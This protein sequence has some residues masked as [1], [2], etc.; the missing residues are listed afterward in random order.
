M[1]T[2]QVSQL[3]YVGLE[4]SDLA[5]WEDFA[6]RILGLEVVPTDLQG[7][8]F[9]RMDENHHRIAL[10]EGPADD[11]SHV[12]WE[13]PDE[14]V[15]RTLAVRLEA[16]GLDVHPG[17]TAEARERRVD[18][19]VKLRDPDG[20]DTEI[21][22]GPLVEPDRPFCS[23]RPISRFVA[24]DL[25]LGHCV[26]NVAD[27]EASMQ[28]YRDGL[29]LLISDFIDIDMGDGSTVTAAFLH[30]GPRHHSVALVEVPSP[31]RMHHV[32]FEVAD[33]DDVGVAHD[34]C[35]DNQIPITMGMGR[36][37]NDRMTSFYAESP[38]G[39]QVEYG[40][41]GRLIDD[42]DWQVQTYDRTSIWGHRAPG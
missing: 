31:K 38:S 32:M 37:P 40:Y 27:Y 11:V 16:Q 10:R 14:D 41:G 2:S 5:A 4:V 3:G 34:L 25:G 33:V 17:T 9:L 1:T 42:D 18:G 22:Y 29:G 6:T 24:G 12:G 36:H 15:L 30:C 20:L 21:Y 7:T 8:V 13:V 39:F 23:P 35:V 28:F 26:L 19:L